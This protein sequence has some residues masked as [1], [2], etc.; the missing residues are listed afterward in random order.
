[1]R[2]KL[3]SFTG[4]LPILFFFYALYDYV[5][6]V[7]TY[8]A[9]WIC[10]LSN[11]LL[12]IAIWTRFYRLAWAALIWITIGTPLWILDDWLSHYPLTLSGFLAHPGALLVGIVKLR[13]RITQDSSWRLA[14]AI[15]LPIQIGSRFF[16]P[17]HLNVNLSHEV[18]PILAPI[19]TSYPI[20]WGC[21][22]VVLSL[23]TYSVEKLLKSVLV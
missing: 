3:S 23:L 2:N 4:L 22:F 13:S 5:E 15:F 20:F 10:N 8:T 18:Y 21:G 7:K 9:F 6:A 16:T 17:P 1:M 19:F 12:G 11:L 14:M